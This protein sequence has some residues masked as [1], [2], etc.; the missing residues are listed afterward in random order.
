MDAVTEAVRSV[1]GVGEAAAAVRRGLR[2]APAP[3]PAAAPAEPDPADATPADLDGGPFTV[4]EGA[5]ATLREALVAA[6]ATAPDKGTIFIR[7]GREDVLRTYPELLDA[8]QRVLSGL[9]A[10]GLRPGDA[11]LFQFDDNEDFLTA[12]WA[13]VLGGFVPTPVG[14]ATTY[15]AA[16]EANRKLHNAWTLLDRPVLLTDDAT[17]GA[18]AD[19]RTLWDEPEVRIL[20]VG[21][22]LDH[23]P[24]APADWFDATPGSPVLNLLTSGSTGVPK[25]V[26]HTNA[27]VAARSL[28]VAAHCGLTEDDVSL[29]WMPFDHVTVAMYNVRDVFLRCMHVNARIEHSLGDPLLWLDW[30]DRYRATNLW[31]P[32]FVFAMA[33]ER[34]DEIRGRS[35]DLSC[36]REITNAGEPVIAATSHR[37]LELLAP[38]GLPADAMRPVWG[39]SETCSGVTYARQHRDDRGAGTVAIDPASLGGLVRHLDPGA[40]EAVVLSTVGCPLPGV[41]LRVVDDAGRVLPEGRLGELRIRGLTMMRGYFANAEANAEAYDADGWFRT[42]DL[43]FVHDGEVVIAGRRKDQII[44]R[45][46]NYMAHEIESVVERVDGVRVSFSAAAGV[47]EPGEESDR[48]VVFVVPRQ[49]GEEALTATAESV[50]STLAREAGIAPDL[51]VPVTEAEFPK[52]PSG[53]IQRSALVAAFRSGVFDGR[54]IGADEPEAPADA[55]LF[56]RRWGPAP[57]AAPAPRAAEG[58]DADG[59]RVVLAEDTDLTRLAVDGSVVTVRRGAGPVREA[60]GRYVAALDD[61][62]AL[63]LL[64]ATVAAD[65]GPVGT[66]ILTLPPEPDGDPHDRLA[67]ATAEFAALAGALADGAADGAGLLVL[68]SGS[69]HAQDGDTVDLGTCALPALVRTAADEDPGRP[70]RLADLP[71]TD[72]GAW[73]AAVRGELADRDRRGVVAVRGGTRLRPLLAPVA[74]GPAADRRAPGLPSAGGRYLVTGGLGGIAHDVAGY[75]VAA[76]GARLLLVGRSPADGERADRLAALRALGDVEYRQ[77]DVADTAALTA[78]IAAAEARWGRGL[79]GVLHLAGADPTAQW[80][81]LERHT[82]ARETPEGFAAHYR[83][84]VAGTLAVADVLE[85][86][87]DAH[88]VLFGSVNGEFGGHSFGAYSA[89]NAFL[90]GFADHWHHERHRPVH[91]LS[92][93]MWTGT[94]MNRGRSAAAAVSRGFR[95]ID[96][97]D[98][99]QLFLDAVASPHHRLAVGPDPSNPAVMDE[100]VPDRLR[101]GE[102]VVAYTAEGVAPE[103]VRAAA[104]AG[105]RRCPVPIRLVEVTAVPKRADGNVDTAALLRDTAP[106]RPRR[107]FTAPV[108]E[109]EEK[110]AALWSQAL[111]GARVGRD[112]SFFDLGGNSIRATRLLALV[113]DAFAVRVG[114]QELYEHPTLAAMAEAIGRRRAA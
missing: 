27:S 20:T 63:R 7:K 95:V 91:C 107:A 75:L 21:A 111:D 83:A 79:D 104:A 50:R 43:A 64:L 109:R 96:P 89:A 29:I 66:V 82:V 16:N 57:A 42:G 69:V 97:A 105:L 36:L 34:A 106:G 47:R 85:T 56:E 55:W 71:A 13:C 28:A 4:P 10:A 113:E 30:V 72:P 24:L 51:V 3:H 6:A 17:A 9:R 46:I 31:A 49:W 39:M 61:R 53:K 44:V 41:R 26:Q 112:T 110:L 65:H 76:H 58:P 1:P 86:R 33:N 40:K 8:A 93:S 68:T 19:V 92:W 60:P 88:L 70:I 87:P 74:P 37:F 22:L 77:L 114:T 11:A 35:W 108:G 102:A 90:A 80:E 101:A 84:K 103:T 45:G 81:D 62:D 100:L 99:L 32:N 25:C 14:V 73:P 15:R 2:P 52:T 59:V 94:G 38:H 98:G 78:A 12:F 18:L 23:A 5:P 54:A 67:R 48:L